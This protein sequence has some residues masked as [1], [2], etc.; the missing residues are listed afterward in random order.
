MTN[1]YSPPISSG[2]VQSSRADSLTTTAMLGH[3]V[4]AYCIVGAFDYFVAFSFGWEP[5]V[6]LVTAVLYPIKLIAPQRIHSWPALGIFSAVWAVALIAYPC[7]LDL[8]SDDSPLG[9]FVCY[10]LMMT[11]VSLATLIFDAMSSTQSSLR[12]RIW[13]SV[14]EIVLLLP[15]VAGMQIVCERFG[16]FYL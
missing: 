6:F 9:L 1:P 16:L 12:T 4:L 11:P 14:V 15:W 3:T 13:R 5:S 8:D 10:F 7:Y 2:S